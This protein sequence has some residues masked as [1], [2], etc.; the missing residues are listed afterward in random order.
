MLR[1]KTVL[2]VVVFVLFSLTACG[3]RIDPPLTEEAESYL[4]SPNGDLIP[5]YEN[6][7]YA[8]LDPALFRED[9]KGR[10]YYDAPGVATYTGIDVSVFQREIDW[11]AVKNDGIDF[12]MLRVGYRGYGSEG[13]IGQD[14]L[15]FE[16][17]NGALAAGLKIGVYFF[18]QATSEKEAAEE[19]R[20][21]LDRI[22]GLQITYPVAYDWEHIDYD[23]ARTDDMSSDLISA[24]A[25]AF[26]DT[27]TQAGYSALIYFNREQG[28]FNYDLS[29]VSRYHFWLAEYLSNPS[30]VYDYK[31]WQ[32][33][34][35]G[36]VNGVEGSVDINISVFDY[37]GSNSIG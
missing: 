7:E 1:K 22:K 4:T 20:F 12:V 30:F 13:K 37:S 34:K 32:Y 27:V 17:Y 15:F 10:M 16:H 19:A 14:D 18:S 11:T 36:T 25:A 26:C 33:S 35:T 31:I 8:V 21:V 28:Y 3:L 9:A 29:M 24:C 6:V 5:S 2:T 23:T